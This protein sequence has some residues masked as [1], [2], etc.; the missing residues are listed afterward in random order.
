MLGWTA[1]GIRIVATMHTAADEVATS[2]MMATTSSWAAAYSI[3][4][5]TTNLDPAGW[6]QRNGVRYSHLNGADRS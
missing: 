1:V 4:V 6:A 5:T 2:I 3:V